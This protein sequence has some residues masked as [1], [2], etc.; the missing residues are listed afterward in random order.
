MLQ[1][2]AISECL[3]YTDLSKGKLKSALGVPSSWQ[4]FLN[5]LGNGA[6]GESS[7][8]DG[9]NPQA[10]VRCLPLGSLCSQGSGSTA[11]RTAS[12]AAARVLLENSVC[13]I[14]PALGALPR[15][16]YSW[17]CYL[18][19]QTRRVRAERV[20]G[21]FPSREGCRS[22]RPQPCLVPVGSVLELYWHIAPCLSL[23][24]DM[25]SE[26]QILLLCP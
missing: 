19:G 22:L 3:S 14:P 24:W 17:V 6:L 7:A 4:W 21:A 25:F 5:S 11:T 26:D 1:G 16:T 13:Q 15:R 23:P 12:S 10:K 8:G 9:V 2:L 18:I 20:H